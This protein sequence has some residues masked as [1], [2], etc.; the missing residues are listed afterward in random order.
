VSTFL[1]G[2]L[3]GAGA[4]VLGAGVRASLRR[5]A[6]ERERVK[7]AIELRVS[8]GVAAG[9][10]LRFGLLH[11]R[12]GQGQESDPPINEPRSF[13][14]RGRSAEAADTVTLIAKTRYKRGLG[15]QFK[16]FVDHK[17]VPFETVSE[18]LGCEVATASVARVPS[19]SARSSS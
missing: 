4:S 18:R 14:T 1:L 10:R 5:A 17:G 11:V 13:K 12:D 8:A 16:C 9:D 2:V 3:T 19:G 15:L 7:A 6:A